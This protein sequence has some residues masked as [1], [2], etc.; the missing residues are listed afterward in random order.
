MLWYCLRLYGNYVCYTEKQKAQ[1]VA[2]P[3][4]MEIIHTDALK[5]AHAHTE[6]E[7]DIERERESDIERANECEFSAHISVYHNELEFGFSFA[8]AQNA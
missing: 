1:F 6:Q 8:S 3:L 2:K 7:S 4:T 5:H